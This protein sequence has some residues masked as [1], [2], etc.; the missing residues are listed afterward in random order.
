[1]DSDTKEEENGNHENDLEGNKSRTEKVV[2]SKIP[3][4]KLK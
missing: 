4:V 1:M 2:S 3:K